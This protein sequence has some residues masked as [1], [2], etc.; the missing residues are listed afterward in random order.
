MWIKFAWGLLN[1]ILV[2]IPKIIQAAAK[3]K[4]AKREQEARL[5]ASKSKSE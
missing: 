3:A 4:R 5:K 2:G 1:V